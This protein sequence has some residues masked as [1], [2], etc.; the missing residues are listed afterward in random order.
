MEKFIK[1]KTSV[2]FRSSADLDGQI[3]KTLPVN[4]VVQVFE[5]VPNTTFY[6]AKLLD[7]TKGFITNKSTYSI[8]F[9]PDWLVTAKNVLGYA[10]QYVD[11]HTDYVFGSSRTNDKDFD[12]SDFMQW[13]LKK[14]ANI[15][16]DWDSRNQ[17]DDGIAA[18]LKSLRTGDLVFFAYSNGYIHH[19]AM[20]VRGDREDS[21]GDQ[22][23]HTY[24]VG[25]G[26]TY[27][28]FSA[29]SYWRDK[30]GLVIA[31]RVIL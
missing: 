10:Q 31:R 23:L 18:D 20:V 30:A 11:A 4:T 1:T 12:C 8:D 7:G 2:N 9:V 29:G 22:L 24:R 26:V 17:S 27:T 16:I 19:V 6:S 25:V 15:T 28:D 14:S 21:K 5:T 3:I 13:I